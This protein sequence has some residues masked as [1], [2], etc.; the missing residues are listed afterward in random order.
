MA[1]IKDRR[2]LYQEELDKLDTLE[3][4]L[5]SHLTTLGVEL[6]EKSD[7]KDK[8]SS[9]TTDKLQALMDSTEPTKDISALPADEVQKLLHSVQAAKES[10]TQKIT[11]ENDKYTGYKVF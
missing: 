4:D 7:D 3:G 1:M 6:E 10:L 8:G 2:E 9:E 11:A 5:Q